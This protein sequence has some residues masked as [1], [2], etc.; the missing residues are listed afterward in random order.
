MRVGTRWTLLALVCTTALTRPLVAQ[1]PGIELALPEGE[2]RRSQGPSIRTIGVLTN[3]Q[4]PDLV[5]SGFPARL[6]YKVERWRAQGVFDELRATAEWDV[7]VSYDELAKRYRVVRAATQRA[8]LT[9]TYSDLRAADSAVAAPFGAP[10][11]PPRSGEKSYYTATVDVEAMSLSDLDEVER[12]LRGEL[13]PAVRG[14]R[15]PGTAVTTGIRTIFVRLLGG[16][17]VQYRGRTGTFRP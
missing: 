8:V 11:T 14:R 13:R 7:I 12:W 4:T 5:R 15:N 6:H 2:A 9:G 16:E 3:G 10:I 1:R 17:R